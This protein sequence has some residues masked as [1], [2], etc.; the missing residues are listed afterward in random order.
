MNRP[1]L[2][3]II[4][5]A[6]LIAAMLWFGR[7]KPLKQAASLI[8]TNTP[9][10]MPLPKAA[11]Q[12]VNTNTNPAPPKVVMNTPFEQDKGQQ[13]KTG[14]SVLNDAPIVFYGRLADQHDAPVANA[15]VTASVRIYNGVQSTVEHL[16]TMSD[17]GG[18]FQI[19]GGKG[20][21]L[22]IMPTK[23]GYVLAGS[24][25]Y[26]KYSYMYSDRF[27]PDRNN[28]VLIK[29]WKLQ[30]AEPLLEI[31]QRYKIHYTNAPVNFDLIA[32]KIVSGGGDLA[33]TVNRLPGIVS[34]QS[35]Q[36]WS[37]E[38]DSVSGGL[39]ETTADEARLTYA[40]PQD[41]YEPNVR[42]EMSTATHSWHVALDQ[43]FFIKSRGGSIYSKIRLIFGI[44]HKP[45]GLMDV[46]L[47]GV[48]NTNGSRNWEATARQ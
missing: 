35:P 43:T 31:N 18:L 21:S 34:E 19:Q 22:G 23:R 44:N 26:F 15:Q 37:V 13:M 42:F 41:G 40:A 2:W 12:P 46:K 30:G 47:S 29:M 6:I 9:V 20:E 48:A 14:L 33:I 17:E 3:F 11:S 8:Q 5:A 7:T 4:V 36:D 10:A 27:S 24:N 32:G 38:V 25:T 28:P 45:D 1:L 39:I 16:T